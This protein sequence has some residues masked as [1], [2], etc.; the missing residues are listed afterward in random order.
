LNGEVDTFISADLY[1]ANGVFRNDNTDI[2]GYLS[3][4]LLVSD[5]LL[6]SGNPII[7]Y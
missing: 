5:M 6:L 2:I 7:T 1:K 3:G 4:N